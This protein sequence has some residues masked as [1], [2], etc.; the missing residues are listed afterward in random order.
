MLMMNVMRVMPE[1]GIQ[2]PLLPGAGMLTGFAM[3]CRCARCGE[4]VSI[5]QRRDEDMYQSVLAKRIAQ[6]RK[7]PDKAFLL[8]EHVNWR[9]AHAQ[10]KDAGD[11]LAAGCD[12]AQLHDAEAR[13]ARKRIGATGQHDEYVSFLGGYDNAPI[14]PYFVDVW[15]DKTF[16]EIVDTHFGSPERSAFL[17]ERKRLLNILIGSN[18]LDL[19]RPGEVVPRDGYSAREAN[20]AMRGW[21][22]HGSREALIELRMTAA[23]TTSIKQATIAQAAV[24]GVG[25]TELAAVT[26]RGLVADMAPRLDPEGRLSLFTG[27]SPHVQMQTRRFVLGPTKE[28]IQRDAD[29]AL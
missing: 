20:L 13:A 11:A 15:R 12:K 24:A 23:I 22:V 6:A 19:T 25:K 10:H 7:N 5:F 9:G 17:R 16:I 14:G 26:V 8:D 27:V 4:P 28:Q 3:E 18:N 29:F 1:T 21:Y 2:I